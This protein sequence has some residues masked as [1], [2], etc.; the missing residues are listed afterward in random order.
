MLAPLLAP[1]S[2]SA[3]HCCA[4]QLGRQRVVLGRQVRV[5]LCEGAGERWF[6]VQIYQSWRFRVTAFDPL[7]SVGRDIQASDRV[8]F[9]CKCA[10]LN[11][12]PIC[13]CTRQHSPAQNMYDVNIQT[14][15]TGL[16][17]GSFD[18]GS[19]GRDTIHRAHRYHWE[20]WLGTPSLITKLDHEM[21]PNSVDHDPI[22]TS[23]STQGTASTK[24][25]GES[26]YHFAGS[27]FRAQ[28]LLF[29]CH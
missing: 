7:H 12:S 17:P 4:I 29:T 8:L 27:R 15:L 9:R 28:T 26:W 11:C 21:P 14:S 13:A 20:H 22:T 5:S 23:T 1:R 2:V 3:A 24:S 19:I 10:K 6:H 25:S 16:H 18:D